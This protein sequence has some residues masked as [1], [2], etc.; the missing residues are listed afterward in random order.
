[1]LAMASVSSVRTGWILRAGRA[2]LLA[3]PRARPFYEGPLKRFLHCTSSPAD[4][5]Y[6]CVVIQV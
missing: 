6:L 3:A 5:H 2:V 1:M 4:W